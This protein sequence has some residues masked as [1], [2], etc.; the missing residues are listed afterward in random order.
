[1]S[2]TPNLGLPLLAAAQAQKH[3]THNEALLALDA[4]VHCAVLSRVLT[5][6]PG[7]PD[8]GDR[9]L[10]AS[11]ASGA[12]AGYAHEIAA[13]MAGSWSYHPPRAG[14]LAFVADESLLL[15][16]DGES[17]IPAT[18]DALQNL[19]RLGLGT[20]ADATNPFA[21]KLNKALWTAREEGE[22][23]TG[24][25]RYTL[26]KESAGHVL[27]LL[28]QSGYSG[29]AEFGL[30]GDDEV[31]LK[32]SADGSGWTEALRIRAD[33]RVGVGTSAAAERLS[34]A[35]NIAPASD[36][37]HSLGTATHRFSAVY[38]VTGVVNTSD[39]RGKQ[40]I[41]P[42]T[43]Q[44]AFSLLRQAAPISFR[45]RHGESGRHFG[46]AAQDWDA[47]LDRAGLESGLV[48][49]PPAE[50]AHARLGLRPDQVT[51]LLHAAILKL[52]D[53][54]AVLKKRLTTREAAT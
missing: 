39:I 49:R 48:V 9:Y 26:N 14:I 1:M 36:G 37:A 44:L 15:L 23:G 31:Q 6:P 30:V 27:S 53:E 43:P 20:V 46:W 24:D 17:W 54:I 34:V 29:R 13:F 12:W 16:H 8:E 40:D 5:S 18:P 25:L 3:V 41:E 33:G 50:E 22:G 7:S 28:L 21:A 11:G 38:A 52:S 42:I 47:A 10:V 4:L 51:A 2:E 32:V 19:T 45:W 35:G